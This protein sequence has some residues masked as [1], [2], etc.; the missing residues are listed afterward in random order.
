MCFF[1][2][3]R[4]DRLRLVFLSP[5]Q[6]PSVL[7][8]LLGLAAARIFLPHPPPHPLL[9]SVC[10]GWVTVT[11]AAVVVRNHFPFVSFFVPCLL[12]H[13]LYYSRRRKLVN[14]ACSLER[15]HKVHIH[16]RPNDFVF[17]VNFVVLLLFA[18]PAGDDAAAAKLVFCRYSCSPTCFPAEVAPRC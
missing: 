16:L 3:V 18:V 12:Y 5:S 8:R 1:V 10:L 15:R 4:G 7:K 2:C 9:L 11:A 14:I 6:L 17:Y 13:M